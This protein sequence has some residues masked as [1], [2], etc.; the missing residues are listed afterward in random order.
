MHTNQ[1]SEDENDITKVFGEVISRYSRADALQDGELVD[2]STTAREAGYK[3]PFA[4]TRALWNTLEKIPTHTP[5][6]D[7]EGRLWDCLMVGLMAIRNA[8]GG[9]SRVVFEVILSIEGS[10]KKMQTIVI[11]LGPGDQAEPVFT[12]GY[13]ED[14]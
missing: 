4:V 5:C 3:F 6:Q 11:D 2:V 1:N 8:K 7:L 12:M 13:R 10:R 9:D 14:F